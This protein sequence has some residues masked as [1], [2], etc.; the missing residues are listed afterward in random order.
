MY[1]AIAGLNHHNGHMYLAARQH[2]QATQSAY[3]PS[4]ANLT[5]ETENLFEYQISSEMD[6]TFATQDLSQTTTLIRGH[7]KK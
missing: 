7:H 3:M 6:N 1:I 5:E 4:S 2:S